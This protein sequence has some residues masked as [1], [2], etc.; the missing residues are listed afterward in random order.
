M[1]FKNLV[2]ELPQDLTVPGVSIVFYEGTITVTSE[3]YHRVFNG[4]PPLG[5]IVEG[6][7]Y[8]LLQFGNPENNCDIVLSKDGSSIIV[9]RHRTIR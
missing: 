7:R 3:G 5:R 2:L 4:H 9:R 8:T 1:F 6:K